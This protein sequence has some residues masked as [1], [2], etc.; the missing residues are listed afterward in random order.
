MIIR[1]SS[2]SSCY[3]IGLGIL[4]LLLFLL[5]LLRWNTSKVLHSTDYFTTWQFSRNLSL[6][7]NNYHTY[8]CTYI[9]KQR[10]K[11]WFRKKNKA[12]I[13]EKDANW[14]NKLLKTIFLKMCE[15]NFLKVTKCNIR[16]EFCFYFKSKRHL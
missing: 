6:S 11:K 2:R 3:I 9:L 1:S 4:M 16:E 8:I 12:I 10:E 7:I 15:E 13:E 5:L 14:E